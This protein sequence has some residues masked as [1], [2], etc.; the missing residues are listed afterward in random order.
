LSRFALVQGV[1]YAWRSRRHLAALHVC[2][3]LSMLG[4]AAA[5]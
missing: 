5:I 4:A 2:K 1:F 3:E